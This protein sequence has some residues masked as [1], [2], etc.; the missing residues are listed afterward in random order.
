MK[1]ITILLAATF[2]LAFVLSIVRS[3]GVITGVNA[4]A[5]KLMMKMDKNI[6]IIDVRPQDQV[7]NE[8][9]RIPRCKNIPLDEIKKNPDILDKYS[10]RTLVF[11]GET[12]Q[13]AKEAAALAAQKRLHV[14]IF[15]GKIH[16]LG[17]IVG[18]KIHKENKT[19]K[20]PTPIFR[21]S[22]VP[23][24]PIN[25]KNENNEEEDFGC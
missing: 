5:L 18:S 7:R 24:E 6:L 13:E 2:L 20:P 23:L 4:D 11:T 25:P 12:E 3:A 1:K 16:E 9:A 21:E 8:P 22:P 10:S 19:E 15:K 14:Y 17:K